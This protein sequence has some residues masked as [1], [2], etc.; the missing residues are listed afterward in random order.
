MD[1]TVFWDVVPCSLVEID[2]RFKGA[3]CHHHQGDREETFSNAY[4][5][6]AASGKIESRRI[7]QAGHVARTGK[8]GNEI[9]ATFGIKTVC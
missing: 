5:S 2:R 3:Y 7:Q 6:A 8:K 9:H 4:T 1:L